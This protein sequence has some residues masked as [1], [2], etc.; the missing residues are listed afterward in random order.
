MEILRMNC[1]ECGATD[2]L[3]V[4]FPAAVDIC[5]QC[6][7]KASVLLACNKPAVILPAVD[8]NSELRDRFALAAMPVLMAK[9]WQ[10]DGMAE[11]AYKFADA[12]ITAS[13]TKRVI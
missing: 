3:A 5:E 8:A 11:E 6:L 10:P 2:V 1:D 13:K 9:A 12:M 4:R 7:L